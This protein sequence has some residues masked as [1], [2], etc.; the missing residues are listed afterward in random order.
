MNEERIREI[1][2]CLR[3]C[4]DFLDRC[5][6]KYGTKEQLC[7]V[8]H[9]NKYGGSGIEHEDWCPI[10]KARR[11]LSAA[12][13]PQGNTLPPCCQPDSN[14]ADEIK[15]GNP[16]PCRVE[17]QGDDE[18]LVTHEELVE[19]LKS[20]GLTES[21]T[22]SYWYGDKP[23]WSHACEAQKLLTEQ[24]CQERIEGIFKDVERVWGW[25]SGKWKDD[26]SPMAIRLREWNAIKERNGAK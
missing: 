26:D 18:G 11:I 12:L 22:F 21:S 8:C 15:A 13:S 16:P 4:H 23:L 2:E 14:C 25:Q 1:L 10:L 17:P 7:L 24:R 3:L 19:Y 5:N 9:S 20:K 6:G